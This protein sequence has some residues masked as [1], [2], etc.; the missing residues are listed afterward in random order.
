MEL[1]AGTTAGKVRGAERDGTLRFLGV[2]FAA[3]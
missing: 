2:P 1:V 3:P